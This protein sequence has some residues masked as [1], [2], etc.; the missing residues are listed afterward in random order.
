MTKIEL[1]QV[2]KDFVEANTP[3][4][5][6]VNIGEYWRA[7][8]I[9]LVFMRLD[10]E[11]HGDTFDDDLW[12]QSKEWLSHIRNNDAF[13]KYVMAAKYDAM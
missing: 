10:A 3:R 8:L 5:Q 4:A 2:V 13:I 1:P 6:G 12:N 9:G 11:N 7:Y